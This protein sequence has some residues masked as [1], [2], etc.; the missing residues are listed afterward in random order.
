MDKTSLGNFAK[1]TVVRK[2]NNYYV[3]YCITAQKDPTLKLLQ[4]YFQPKPNVPLITQK[5]ASTAIS[6][7]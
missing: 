2:N 3:Q 7:P 1:L 5:K 4:N 6:R